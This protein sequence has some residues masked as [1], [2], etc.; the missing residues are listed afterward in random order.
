VVKEIPLTQGKVALVDDEEYD[1]LI[2]Y[3]WFAMQ[4]IIE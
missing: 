2:K 3:K 4:K 1:E